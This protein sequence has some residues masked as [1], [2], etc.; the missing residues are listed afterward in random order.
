MTNQQS[1][2][3]TVYLLVAALLFQGLSG[4][5]GGIGL[6]LDPSGRS[7]QLPLN[8]L[9]G[10]PFSDYLIPGWILLLVLGI[11]PLIVFYGLWRR[12]YWGWL[13]ALLVGLA[14]IIWIA[15]E[16]LI[17][18]YQPQPPLQLI[19]GTLGL[20]ILILALLPGVQRYYPTGNRIE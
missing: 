11:F 13:G 17:I 8:W 15:V 6:I 1:R 5:A 12:Q 7:L 20:I 10:S 9:E 3:I 4:V 19:Y 2:P 18:G 14:L 16:I